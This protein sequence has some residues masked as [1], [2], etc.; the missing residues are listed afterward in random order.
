MTERTL[1][2]LDQAKDRAGHW[3]VLYVGLVAP[4]FPLVCLTRFTAFMRTPR[5]LEPKLHPATGVARHRIVE[6]QNALMDTEASFTNEDERR[7]AFIA[8]YGLVSWLDNN[9]GKILAKNWMKPACEDAQILSILATMVIM[10]G[11][12]A[13][14]E[15][16]IYMKNL[17][18][19]R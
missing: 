8:Y 5:S 2:W 16:Q 17:W 3:C 19:Y 18:P 1:R 6:K 14:G 9:I 11:H 15:S 10:S 4:H 13:C 7:R 12:A